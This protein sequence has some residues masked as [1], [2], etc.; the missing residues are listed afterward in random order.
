MKY[1]GSKLRKGYELILAFFLEYKVRYDFRRYVR[2]KRAPKVAGNVIISL[3]SYDKRF[4]KLSVTLKSLIVQNVRAS[5]IIIWVS[6][7]DKEKLPL[8]VRELIEMGCVDALVAKNCGPGTKILP[9]LEK[10]PSF[11]IVTADD[12]IYY[13]PE[14]LNEILRASEKYPNCVVAHRVHKVVFDNSGQV[15][16]YDD[17][18]QDFKEEG[19]NP[20]YFATGVGGVFYPA[21]QFIS[22]VL[23][24]DA[25]LDN[26]KFQD[27]VWLFFMEKLSQIKVC[28]SSFSFP[29]IPW[30]STKSFGLNVKNCHGEND[31]SITKMESRYGSI[32]DITNNRNVD[33]KYD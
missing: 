17:W 6:Q 30:L 22:E 13:P 32:F 29:L 33:A 9:A 21:N 18:F 27:D 5:K 20:D 24:I 25:Y 15:R 10:F 19:Y 12:D 4:K 14:W 2:Q 16:K 23:N 28:R 3:T 26:C 8:D 7:E 1:L 11:D 31:K